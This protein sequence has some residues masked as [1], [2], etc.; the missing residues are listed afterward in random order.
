MSVAHHNKE[1]SLLERS[2]SYLMILWEPV[3]SSIY[4]GFFQEYMDLA[5]TSHYMETYIQL[6]WNIKIHSASNKGLHTIEFQVIFQCYFWATNHLWKNHATFVQKGTFFLYGTYIN[7]HALLRCRG[8][9]GCMLTHHIKT[10]NCCKLE[11]SDR[12]T[13]DFRQSFG[14]LYFSLRTSHKPVGQNDVG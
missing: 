14:R 6:L 4:Y 5:D 10:A 12:E 7:W 9:Y 2:S 13:G 3:M 11:S 1:S 8:K